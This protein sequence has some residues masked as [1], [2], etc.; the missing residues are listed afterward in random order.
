[1]FDD[2]CVDLVECTATVGDRTGEVGER[3]VAEPVGRERLPGS[4]ASGL[5]QA[6]QIVRET[7]EHF[8]GRGRTALNR[9]SELMRVD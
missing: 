4:S 7:H 8:L 5:E 2:L 6:T 1:M 9:G 3:L